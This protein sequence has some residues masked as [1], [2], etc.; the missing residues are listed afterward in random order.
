[1]TFQ[2]WLNLNYAPSSAYQFG[3]A[4]RAL[5]TAAGLPNAPEGPFDGF[6]PEFVAVRVRQ[7]I[8]LATPASQ[9]NAMGAWNRWTD[10]LR[11]VHQIT[12]PDITTRH[13]R[14]RTRQDMVPPAGLPRTVLAAILALLRPPV[15]PGTPAFPPERLAHAWWGDVDTGGQALNRASGVRLWYRDKA[16]PAFIDTEAVLPWI[17]LAAWASG[18][19]QPFT[20]PAPHVPLIPSSRGGLAPCDPSQLAA[21]QPALGIVPLPMQG[22][23]RLTFVGDDLAAEADPWLVAPTAR[24]HPMGPAPTDLD[25]LAATLRARAAQY[26]PEA[27]QRESLRAQ[28]LDE[29]VPEPA[30]VSRPPE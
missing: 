13:K 25:Q 6:H 26:A 16:L 22:S 7:A 9:R 17:V 3:T 23:L 21:V 28:V 4:L 11:E 1:M 12:L 15:R 30:P 18:V 27:P 8:S 29:P 20:L 19:A 2:Q 24:P 14:T 10:Y 5:L